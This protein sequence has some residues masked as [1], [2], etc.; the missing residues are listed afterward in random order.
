MESRYSVHDVGDDGARSAVSIIDDALSPSMVNA[1]AEDETLRGPKFE[2]AFWAGWERHQAGTLLQNAIE[3]IWHVLLRDLEPPRAGFEYWTRYADG[4]AGGGELSPHQD[5]DEELMNV[6]G[7]TR[8]PR[9][10]CVFYIAASDLEGGEL[11]VFSDG[12]ESP[13][14]SVEPRSNRLVVFDSGGLWHRVRKMR[15]GTRLALV[16]N[17]WDVHP[18]GLDTGD[19]RYDK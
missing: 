13:P 5:K 8:S 2:S 18:V 12:L 11:E 14:I 3:Q 16:T 9:V 15:R 10:G 4:E 1:L 7:I 17:V 19:I 6:T